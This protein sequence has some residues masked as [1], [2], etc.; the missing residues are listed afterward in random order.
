MPNKTA[1]PTWTKEDACAALRWMIDMAQTDTFNSGELG[2]N[3]ITAVTYAVKE[4]DDIFNVR[5][6]GE[7]DAVADILAALANPDSN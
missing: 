1:N 7:D 5:A 4:L 6:A 3:A 2:R